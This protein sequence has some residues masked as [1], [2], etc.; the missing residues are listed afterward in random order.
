MSTFLEN[1]KNT[2]ASLSHKHTISDITDYEVDTALSPTS[3]NPVQNKVVD[4]EFDAMVEA[5]GVLETAID[6][7]ASSTH[8]HAITEVTNLQST[9]NAKVPTTRTVNGK[10]L[11]SDITL[12]AS[13]VGADASGSASSALSSAKT[14]I[15]NSIAKKTQVQII[16]W[17]AND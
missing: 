4:A 14:Y 5:M 10:A 9:L 1:L 3:T 16:T 6:G 11:S 2:F 13:D 17:E 15:D 8:T 7:K 12:S